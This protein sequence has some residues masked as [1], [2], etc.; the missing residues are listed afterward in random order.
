MAIALAAAERQAGPCPACNAA[1]DREAPRMP[2]GFTAQ[3]EPQ[4]TGA[5][6]RALKVGQ[7]VCWAASTNDLGTVI[8]ATWSAVIIEWDDGLTASIEHND[9]ARVERAPANSSSL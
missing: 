4:M 9:M 5:Q 8:G 3:F 2:S 1:N 6:S 7:R